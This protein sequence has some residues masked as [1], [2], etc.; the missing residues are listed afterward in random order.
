MRHASRLNPSYVTNLAFSSETFKQLMN[1]LVY[2]KIFPVKIGGNALIQFSNFIL[3]CIKEESEKISSFD[4]K[5]QRI[6]DFYCHSLMNTS[7]DNKLCDVHKLIFPISH[8]E[9]DVERGFNLNKNS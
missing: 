2:L 5:K 1:K 7:K 4:P 8:G 3:N 6:D 9:D